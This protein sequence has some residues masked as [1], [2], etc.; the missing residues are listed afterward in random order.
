MTA[1]RGR[2]TAGMSELRRALL[3]VGTSAA[4]TTAATFL[5]IHLMLGRW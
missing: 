4:V 1:A 5:L 3:I 2:G